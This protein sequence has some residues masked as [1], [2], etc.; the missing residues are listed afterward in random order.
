MTL[1]LMMLG[2]VVGSPG[3]QAVTRLLPELIQQHKPHVVIANG[4]NAS[5]GSGL[6]ASLFNKL[7]DAGIDGVTLGDHVY[8]KRHIMATLQEKPNIIVPA[9]LPGGAVGK[10]FMAI[11][12]PEPFAPRKLYVFTLLGRVFIDMPADHPFGV[13]DRILQSLP[14]PAPLVLAELHAEATAE[15]QALAHYLDGRVVAA[16]GSHTH[17]PT[18]DAR[19]LPKGT[20]YLTDLG[21]CGPSL[22]IIGRK[23]DRVLKY[24]TTSM[25]S[26]FD[27]A[28][29]EPS[30]CGAV[31]RIDVE[32]RRAVSIERFECFDRQTR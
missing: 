23:V 11:A 7:C 10:R 25:P 2:D 19:V 8:K 6:T 13:A 18:A 9:N 21:M 4:E 30:V 15:K 3:M 17:V 27:V 22:S 1:T 26:P 12:L 24:M 29:D 5:D 20:A 16:L 31:V 32:S 28:M 14:D